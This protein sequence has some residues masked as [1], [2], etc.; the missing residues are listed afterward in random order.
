MD[1]ISTFNQRHLAIC[2]SPA[3]ICDRLV[4]LWLWLA[5]FT[6]QV[7]FILSEEKNNWLSF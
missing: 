4:V 3:V 7:Q 6:R 2:V 1:G 5:F